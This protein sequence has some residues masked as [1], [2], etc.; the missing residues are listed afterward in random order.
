MLIV[1]LAKIL[2]ITVSHAKTC[3]L[4]FLIINALS[5]VLKKPMKI[6][7]FARIVTPRVK[8]VFL[9]LINLAYLV[10]GMAYLTCITI[11]AWL[12]ALPT[13]LQKIL[14]A[15]TVRVHA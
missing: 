6:L 5:N 3:Y 7:M 8:A 12:N 4:N 1:R 11:N 10:Q 13:P 9:V 15:L 2:Q 14:D